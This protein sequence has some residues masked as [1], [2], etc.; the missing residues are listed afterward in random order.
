GGMYNW[1]SSPNVNNCTFSNNSAKY[2]GG[3]MFNEVYS[4][5]TVTDCNFNGNSAAYYRGG[6]MYNSESRPVVKDC[7]FSGN[8]AAYFGGGM[9]NLYSSPTVNNCT[10][11]ENSAYWGGGMGNYQYSSPTVNNCT[12]ADNNAPNGRAMAC[13]S[14][15]QSYPSTVT[16]LNCIIWNGSDWLWNND[17]STIAATYSDV[18][19]GWPG[20]GNIN[21]DPCFVE[22]DS[23][24]YHLLPES[25]CINAGD[26]NF[27]PEPNETDMDGEQR[28]MLGRV[29]M[30]ADEFNPFEVTFEVVNKRRIDR[31]VFKYD[32]KV[33][34]RN[35][36]HSA[37]KNLQL[38]LAKVPANMTIVDPQ[39]SFASTE[40]EPGQSLTSIDTCTFRV[41]RSQPIDSAEI[42]WWVRCDIIDTGQT[43]QH[44]A[45][46]ILYLEPENITGELTGEGKIDF[47]DLAELAGQWLWVGPAGSVPEDITGDGIVN[48]R[49]FAVLAEH[50]LEE[51]Q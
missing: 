45:S 46:S 9:C 7:T 47:G 1:H 25:P 29:D 44:T 32:C 21:A 18:Q 38:E 31:T 11:T 42:A 16:M 3:G 50:R 14:D 39:V 33:T 15:R 24:D 36:W 8:S 22:P 40:L 4:S 34:V 27:I 41:D 6:G 26:P 23:N 17:H 35:R 43:I 2:D 10:F 30:G 51:K 12:I 5:P 49:D 37:L 20:T 28:V 19:G 48:L 13:D